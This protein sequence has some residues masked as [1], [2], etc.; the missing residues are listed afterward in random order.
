[1]DSSSFFGVVGGQPNS[2]VY[3]WSIDALFMPTY[4]PWTEEEEND[5]IEQ[6]ADGT[7]LPMIQMTLQR[8][9]MARPRSMLAIK[10]RVGHLYSE[11]MI[12]INIGGGMP[13]Y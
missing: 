12:N 13:R 4:R 2:D 3:I 6:L 7:P 10:A 9:I 5:L 8:P 1:M 11:G